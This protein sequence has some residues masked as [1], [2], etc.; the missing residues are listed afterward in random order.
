MI[1]LREKMIFASRT[2]QCGAEFAIAK[3]A[4]E[5]RDSADD[6][7]HEQRESRLNILQLKAETREDAGADNVGNHD[8]TCS[9]ETDRPPRRCRLNSS[10]LR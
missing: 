5:R 10:R 1:N 9:D 3:R 7:K 4:A 2:R 6:P 8:R